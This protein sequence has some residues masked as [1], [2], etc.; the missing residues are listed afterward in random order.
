MFIKG[1]KHIV[2]WT[3]ILFSIC[4][5]WAC[6]QRRAVIE[7]GVLSPIT[8]TWNSAENRWEFSFEGAI[9]EI[10][11]VECAIERIWC[12]WSVNYWRG[13][14]ASGTITETEGGRIVAHGI[15]MFHMEGHIHDERELEIIVF[16]EGHDAKG[17]KIYAEEDTWS[18]YIYP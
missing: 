14:N 11:G 4:Q 10:N 15:F 5:F 16:A 8:Q 7:L 3:V 12:D 9:R 17:N 2:H 6:N 18:D 1:K 13:T